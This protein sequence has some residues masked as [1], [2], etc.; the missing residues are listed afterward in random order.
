MNPANGLDVVKLADDV[1]WVCGD[2]DGVRDVLDDPDKPLV[3]H[4]L[5]VIEG[6]ELAAIR[7]VLDDL[8]A[9]LRRAG[10]S[11]QPVRSHS[12]SGATRPRP[13]GSVFLCPQ[14]L[15]STAQFPGPG[16]GVP[17]CAATGAAL[18]EKRF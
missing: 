7:A 18:R 5:T 6:G 16:E 1:S 17:V 14:R 8:F 2:P 3:T 12:V 10:I 11:F 13:A 4:A 15:C 9:A